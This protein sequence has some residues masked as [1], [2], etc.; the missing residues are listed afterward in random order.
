MI[1]MRRM[2]LRWVLYLLCCG[3]LNAVA[4]D[5]VTVGAVVLS[6]AAGY[7][8][9]NVADGGTSAVYVDAEWVVDVCC[10]CCNS[11]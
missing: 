3:K 2:I 11:I 9:E 6:A 1:L 8:A 4:L 5:I 10:D 7:V